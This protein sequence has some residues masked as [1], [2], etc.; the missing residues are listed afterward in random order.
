MIVE[1]GYASHIVLRYNSN[2]T[3]IPKKIVELWRHFRRVDINCSIEAYGELNNYIRYPSKWEILE[4][5]MYFLDNLSYKYINIKIYIHTTLQAYNVIKIP[6]LLN[7]LRYA[8]FKSLH[9]IPYFIFV[10]VPEWLSP[11]LFPKKMRD[12][13]ADKILK[14]LNEHKAFFLTYNKYH[15]GWSRERIQI[16]KEFCGMMKNDSTYEKYL[17]QFIEETKKHDSLRKQSVLDVL[18]E[19]KEFFSQTFES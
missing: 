5:N 19:L 10:D 2:Y 6:E 18:P 12:E 16:L 1:E 8:E 14:S 9:R 15:E 3:V 4:K 13:I 11:V 7:Y 17:G